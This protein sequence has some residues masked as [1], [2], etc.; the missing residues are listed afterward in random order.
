MVWVFY[1]S[2]FTL[3]Y[4]S[5]NPSIIHLFF[6]GLCVYVSTYKYIEDYYNILMN[7]VYLWLFWN[8]IK[9]IIF[10][11]YFCICTLTLWFQCL[12]IY[13]FFY[14]LLIIFKCFIC[15]FIF[16]YTFLFI[17][18]WRIKKIAKFQNPMHFTYTHISPLS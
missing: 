12:I 4:D 10:Y 15:V 2:N 5:R 9:K 18:I 3:K 6:S 7:I 13:E 14:Y 11:T 8:V 17:F 1:L 16:I